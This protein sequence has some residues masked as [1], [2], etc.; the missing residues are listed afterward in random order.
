[1]GTRT[2][3][4]SGLGEFWPPIYFPNVSSMKATIQ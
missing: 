3:P 2:V 1:M 4:E